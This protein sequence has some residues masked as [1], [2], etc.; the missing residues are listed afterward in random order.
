MSLLQDI[1]ND[2]IKKD[3]DVSSV[4]R[5]CLVLASRLDSEELKDW[6]NKELN[7][8][9]NKEELPD[10]RVIQVQSKGDF[11]G[12]FQSGLKNANI[13]LCYIPKKYRAD[14]EQSYCLQPIS[15]Y[16]SLVN[17]SKGEN[18]REPWSSDFIVV[19]G[20]KIYKGM[21]CLSAWKEIPNTAVV[22]LVDS[23]KN[24]ML[25]FVLMVETENPEAGEVEI[26][27]ERGPIKKEKVSQIFNNTVYGNVGNI[28]S[29]NSNVSQSATFNIV[30]GDFNSLKKQ[31]EE[32]DVSEEEVEEL[33][34]IVKKDDTEKVKETKTLGKNVRKWIEKITK[35]SVSLAKGVTTEIIAKAILLY[36]G[37]E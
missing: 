25:N 10:Y 31:L 12:A 32:F 28:S 22:S 36:Y 3:V 26:S 35:T 15:A 20:E 7:G 23:V 34:E 1:Q 14:F 17:S 8:Y 27:K 21:N 24:R 11:S 30:E 18:L 9:E 29:S 37:V 4:L 13:P 16:E 19:L 33:K 5:K 2:L 6:A